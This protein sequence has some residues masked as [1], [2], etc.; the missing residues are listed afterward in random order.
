[1]PLQSRK[2][3]NTIM[4]H[5]KTHSV[6]KPNKR[7]RKA[8]RVIY[9]VVLWPRKSLPMARTPNFFPGS[10]PAHLTLQLIF[11]PLMMRMAITITNPYS[12]LIR[13]HSP[14]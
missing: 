4:F 13:K 1:M 8:F 10:C 14:R 7:L 9:F 6:R 5:E 3:G 12:I 2:S 11:K